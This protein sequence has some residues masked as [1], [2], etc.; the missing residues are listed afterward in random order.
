MVPGHVR[1]LPPAMGDDGDIPV[2]GDDANDSQKAQRQPSSSA[3]PL[4]IQPPAPL[5]L[6]TSIASAAPSPSD[7]AFSPHNQRRAELKKRTQ[8]HALAAHTNDL[9]ATF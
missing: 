3:A 8:A 2:V 7:V 9:P 1:V 6:R 4:T 5:V